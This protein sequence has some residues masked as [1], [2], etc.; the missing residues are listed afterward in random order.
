MSQPNSDSQSAPLST[1]QD[2]QGLGKRKR[3]PFRRDGPNG[4]PLA[5]SPRSRDLPSP[6]SPT[7]TR[8]PFRRLL[9]AGRR[10]AF[11]G[12][13]QI[14][15]SAP[16]N[17][18]SP[19]SIPQVHLS[20]PRRTLPFI[21]PGS[22]PASPA[23]SHQSS[24]ANKDLYLDVLYR[25][26]LL[27]I[28]GDWKSSFTFLIECDFFLLRDQQIRTI[29]FI[30]HGAQ[31]LFRNS[32]H[33]VLHAIDGVTKVDIPDSDYD[34]ELLRTYVHALLHRLLLALPALLL[35]YEFQKGPV[36]RLESV[37]GRCQQFLDGNWAALYASALAA[38]R[39]QR[40]RTLDPD[41]DRQQQCKNRQALILAKKGNFTKAYKALTQDDLCKKDT[42]T[43]LRSLHRPNDLSILKTPSSTCSNLHRLG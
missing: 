27:P 41:P 7:T 26:P 12:S 13:S 33:A 16:T 6:L 29:D 24:Q 43:A 8:T 30:P 14:S 9:S 35:T 1:S 20:S 22:S 5:V 4:D 21:S 18:L 17:V 3:L 38:F 23:H 10:N 34:T 39:P 15:D 40:P 37:R 19:A 2:S 31:K 32:Y 42:I 11:Y 28:C 25:L 36:S